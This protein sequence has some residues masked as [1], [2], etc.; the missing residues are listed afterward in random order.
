MYFFQK[1]GQEHN[2]II[3]SIIVILIQSYYFPKQLFGT[4]YSAQKV[5]IRLKPNIFAKLISVDH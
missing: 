4:Q 1:W 2:L 3:G 5:W